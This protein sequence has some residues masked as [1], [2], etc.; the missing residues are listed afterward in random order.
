MVMSAPNDKITAFGGGSFEDLTRIAM[1]N[2]PLWT[3]LFLENKDKLLPHIKSLGEQ[4]KLFEEMIQNNEREKLEEI[5]RNVRLHRQ[6]MNN[7]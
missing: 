5:L 4:L 7:N 6:A 2:A 3:E 1:I